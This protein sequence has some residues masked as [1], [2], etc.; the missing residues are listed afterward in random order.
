LQR[1]LTTARSAEI[2]ALSEYNKALSALARR[3]GSTLR[4]RGIN[5]DPE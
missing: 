3:E 1:D 2:S 5:L 4:R